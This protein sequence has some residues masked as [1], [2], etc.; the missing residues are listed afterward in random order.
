MTR[1]ES[2]LP[3]SALEATES[4]TEMATPEADDS[5]ANEPTQPPL[6][7]DDVARLRE[8]ASRAAIRK[9]PAAAS[10]AGR[11]CR[12]RA[13]Q[14]PAL[15][16]YVSFRDFDWVLLA[17]V[18]LI[19]ALGVVEIYSATLGT[20]FMGVHI[21]QVYWVLGGVAL[22]FAMSMFN[23]QALMERVPVFYIVSIAS[24]LAVEMFGK[25]YLGAR[26]WVQL[27]SFHFQPSEWVKLVLILAMA[28]YFRRQ[29]K[30][31]CDAQDIVKAGALVGIPMLMVLAQPDLGTAL[32]Y[33]PIAVMGLVPGRHEGQTC[34]CYNADCGVCWPR[35]RG[36]C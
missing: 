12:G 22:M 3:Q 29:L 15:S 9:K 35:W 18:L 11:A 32:T 25:K 17:L 7:Q 6:R 13:S 5:A 10:R 30:S 36:T 24:L 21:K 27:G 20:K 34:R 8:A 14:E 2:P 28:K 31:E 19:C 33:L 26:R 23:Y 1:K 4:H 16:R